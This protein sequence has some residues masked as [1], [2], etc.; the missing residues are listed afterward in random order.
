VEGGRY[1]YVNKEAQQELQVLLLLRAR[2]QGKREGGGRKRGREGGRERGRGGKGEREGGRE[3][4]EGK[5]RRE[6]KGG[7]KGGRGRK[8]CPEQAE[9]RQ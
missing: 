5:E 9:K 3:K 8:N 6:G 1:P 2:A 7:K 4:G